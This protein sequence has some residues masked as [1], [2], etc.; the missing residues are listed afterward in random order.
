MKNGKHINAF[1][2]QSKKEIGFIVAFLE[3]LEPRMFKP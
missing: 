2:N 1:A 3:K